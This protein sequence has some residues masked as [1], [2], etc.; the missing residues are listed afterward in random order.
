MNRRHIIQGLSWLF[1]TLIM[2]GVMIFFHEET[3]AEVAY[4]ACDSDVN[5]TRTWNTVIVEDT[6]GC[7]DWMEPLQAMNEIVGYNILPF[8][9]F[10]IS[11]LI[12]F[13]LRE[14]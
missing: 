6:S 5:I 9:V 7:E 13:W 3:H 4:K 11:I 14:D 1:L 10:G 2:V 12:M 8:L